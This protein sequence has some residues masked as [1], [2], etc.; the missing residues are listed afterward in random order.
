MSVHFGGTNLSTKVRFEDLFGIIDKAARKVIKERMYLLK[1]DVVNAWPVKSGRSK[2]GWS[3]YA[4]R[5]GWTLSNAVKSPE[6][7]DYVPQLWIGMPVGSRQMPL[8]GD[9]ILQMHHE[10][11]KAELKELRL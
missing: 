6:G 1:D 9:P 7:F 4:H 10:L 8:G 11:L 3:V 5:S 2:M